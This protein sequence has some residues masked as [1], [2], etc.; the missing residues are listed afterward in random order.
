[1]I[2]NLSSLKNKKTWNE[3]RLKSE[4]VIYN[5]A[6]KILNDSTFF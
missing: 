3:N 6:N 2:E 1:M 4:D 5:L